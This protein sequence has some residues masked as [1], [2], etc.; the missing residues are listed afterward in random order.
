MGAKPN[1][2]IVCRYCDESMVQSMGLI[3]RKQTNLPQCRKDCKNC[4]ACIEVDMDGDKQHVRVGK[5][6]S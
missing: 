5:S 1:R 3:G 2:I 4:M 6:R